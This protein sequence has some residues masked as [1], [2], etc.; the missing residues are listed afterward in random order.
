MT[1]NKKVIKIDNLGKCYRIGVKEQIHDA[2][3][4]EFPDEVMRF[5]L[6]DFPQM[7]WLALK[8]CCRSPAG[9]KHHGISDAATESGQSR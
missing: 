1:L 9:S 8:N 3:V 7:R 4:K 2:F 5:G 6:L